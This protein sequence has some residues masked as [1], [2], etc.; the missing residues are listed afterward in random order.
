MEGGSL[1]RGWSATVGTEG[2]IHSIPG[3]AVLVAEQS[4]EN[5]PNTA[6]HVC[7]TYTCSLE[8]GPDEPGIGDND[9]TVGM[10]PYKGGVS[11]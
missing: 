11:R 7:A 9:L 3:I 1:E 5:R 6:D 8:H 4:A 10:W 2:R